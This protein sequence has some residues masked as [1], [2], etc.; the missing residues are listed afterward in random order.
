MVFQMTRLMRISHRRLYGGYTCSN[1][2]LWTCKLGWPL[3]CFFV[4][5]HY[6]S[7]VYPDSSVCYNINLIS[8]RLMD[9]HSRITCLVEPLFS[10]D[11]NAGPSKLHSPPAFVVNRYH[12]IFIVTFLALISYS[13]R[14]QF[15]FWQL[16]VLWLIDRDSPWLGTF[17]CSKQS[18][19]LPILWFNNTC[20]THKTN[21]CY[22]LEHC[23]ESFAWVTE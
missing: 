16:L 6:E 1:L 10:L 18:A 12:R 11:L 9:V 15:T 20:W 22:N 21:I 4:H 8:A 17:T 3:S 5:L 7:F 19:T 14:L 13:L 23:L 2:V